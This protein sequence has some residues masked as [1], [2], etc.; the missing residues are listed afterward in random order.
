[1]LFTRTITAIL[2]SVSAD[3]DHAGSFGLK[4]VGCIAL[5]NTQFDA[6]GTSR[7]WSSQLYVVHDSLQVWQP[8]AQQFYCVAKTR[9]IEYIGGK[10][11]GMN[12]VLKPSIMAG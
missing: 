2:I 6:L 1:M 12:V 11:S 9:C 4:R 3:K 5:Q 7:M 8:C 10:Y